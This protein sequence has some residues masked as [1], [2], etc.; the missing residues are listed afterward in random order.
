MTIQKLLAY[1]VSI[2]V[3]QVACWNSAE[4]KRKFR[5][6]GGG[7]DL[8]VQSLDDSVQRF[9]QYHNCPLGQLSTSGP[10]A[11][12]GLAAH[13]L[14]TALSHAVQASRDCVRSIS[15]SEIAFFLS[16]AKV[17]CSVL[18]FRSIGTVTVG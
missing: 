17:R 2:R 13:S 6:P 8:W 14:L 9:L 15:I 12:F 3:P 16:L 11:S 7:S 18:S 5:F 10:S 1:R 4:A